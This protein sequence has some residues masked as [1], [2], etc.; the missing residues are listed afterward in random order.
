MK[1]VQSLFMSLVLLG[2]FHGVSAQTVPARSGQKPAGKK[3]V[4][5]TAVGATPNLTTYDGPVVVNTQEIGEKMRSHSRPTD[6]LRIP[7]R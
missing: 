4:P 5:K 6:G 2:L 3:I 1:R 7:V